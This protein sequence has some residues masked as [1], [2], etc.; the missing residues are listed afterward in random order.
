MGYSAAALFPR[1][2]YVDPVFS[3]DACKTCLS[4]RT[5]RNQMGL[6]LEQKLLIALDYEVKNIKIY[7]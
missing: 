7:T 1:D 5:S 3:S 6:W 2:G 4:R